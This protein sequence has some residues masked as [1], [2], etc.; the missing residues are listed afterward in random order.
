[1]FDITFVGLG[2]LILGVVVSLDILLHKHRPVSAVLWLCTV[3]FFPIAGPLFYLTFGMDRVRRGAAAR[4]ATATLVAQR[5]LAHPTAERMAVNS[6]HR[7]SHDWAHHPARRLLEATDRAV[8]SHWFVGGNRTRLLVDGDQFYPALV[9]AIR[10]ARTTIH[11]QTYIFARDRFGW[12]LLQAL[13]RKAAEGVTVRLLYDRFGSTIAHF[14]RMFAAARAAG[15][16]ARSITQANPLKG[17]FQINL[18]NHRKVAVIDGELGFV[19]G[20]NLSDENLG[21]ARSGGPIRDYHLEI[22]GPGVADLQLSFLQDWYFATREPLDGMLRQDLFPRRG[23]VGKALVKVIPAGP[24]LHGH[25]LDDAIFAAIVAAEQSVVIV[26]PYFVPDEPIVEAV[27]SAALRGVA[28]TVVVPARNNHWYTGAAARSLYPPLLKAGVRI[29]ERRPPFM[30]AKAL[31]I[32]ETMAFLGS[33]NLDYRSLH[34][35]FETNV[36]VVDPELLANLGNQLVAEIAASREV[37]LHDHLAR[38]IYHRLV[39]NFCFLFQPLL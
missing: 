12:E 4:H 28:V 33:A 3:W 14:S 5:A 10:D 20:I 34:L 31:V 24:V 7:E 26:T 29:F 22:E 27:R 35:N 39:E 32:D 6:P 25:G 36:Q 11:I 23:P 9:E 15:V 17:R 8:R 18:R 19:G 16:R 21:R 1:M 38:P 2:H 13:Q 37:T 30:H